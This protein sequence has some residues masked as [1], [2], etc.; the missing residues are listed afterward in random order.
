MMGEGAISPDGKFFAYNIGTGANSAIWIVRLSD[1]SARR[2]PASP[3]FRYNLAWSTDGRWLAYWRFRTRKVDEADPDAGLYVLDVRS[4][5]LRQLDSLSDPFRRP[6]EISW[7]SDGRL[8]TGY[9]E[10][11][12]GGS[13]S[14]HQSI[15]RRPNGEHA[16]APPIDLAKTIYSLAPDGR[17]A[18]IG[19]CCGGAATAV[20][21]IDARGDRCVA[22]PL[23]SPSAELHWDAAGRRLYLFVADSYPKPRIAYRVDVA[24]GGASRLYIPSIP[25]T[26]ITTTAAG[27][28]AYIAYDSAARRSSL[29]IIPAAALESWPVWSE[30]IAACPPL[31]KAVAGFVASTHRTDMDFIATRYADSSRDVALYSISRRSHYAEDFDTDIG[32][33]LRS[34]ARVGWISTRD[35]SSRALT[36]ALRRTDS[37]LWDAELDAQLDS[38]PIIQSALRRFLVADSVAPAAEIVR[39]VARDA[40]MMREAGLATSFRYRGHHPV[41]AEIPHASDAERLAIDAIAAPSVRGDVE[42]LAAIGQIPEFRSSERVWAALSPQLKRHA[43]ASPVAFVRLSP[44]AAQYVIL[45][46]VIDE[47]CAA[48]VESLLD[49][50]PAAEQN[51]LLA[52]T[53]ACTRTRSMLGIRASQALVEAI[54]SSAAG[55]SAQMIP[56]VLQRCP[57]ASS[58]ARVLDAIAR[59]DERYRA[60]SRWA[61]SRSSALIASALPMPR[62]AA[63]RPPPPPPPVPHP[64][65][66]ATG[67][68]APPPPP[69]PPGMPSRCLGSDSISAELGASLG[70]RVTQVSADSICARAVVALRRIF[71]LSGP[72][73]QAAY[74]FF[75]GDGI[76]AALPPLIYPARVMM[77][78]MKGDYLEWWREEATIPATKGIY[79]SIVTI[80]RPGLTTPARALD[81]N[82]DTGAAGFL[83]DAAALFGMPALRTTALPR[84]VREIRIW[85]LPG[86]IQP[87]TMRRFQL[88]DGRV[89]SQSAAWWTFP[90]KDSAAWRHHA[91]DWTPCR[92]GVAAGYPIRDLPGIT[93]CVSSLERQASW[94]YEW[95]S[96]ETAGIWRV[97][98]MSEVRHADVVVS[99]GGDLVIE[100][101]DGPYYRQYTMQLDP[102]NPNALPDAESRRRIVELLFRDWYAPD[103]LNVNTPTKKPPDR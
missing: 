88:R 67:R 81:L 69:P 41:P 28:L 49:A 73:D 46:C 63:P 52:I 101:R 25:S 90:A 76:V 26:Q 94:R 32:I 68:P 15:V 64:R 8:V 62:R 65:A 70:G 75:D 54:D 74:V 99:D 40:A 98:Q 11:G 5:A 77:I 97:P 9:W 10:M 47:Q 72:D 30:T 39:V 37:T 85:L 80:S 53:S 17:I 38:L 16:S 55:R 22:G 27:D 42:L 12:F 89:T 34:G 96:L 44:I 57:G 56:L 82:A 13:G 33:A 50:R 84:G 48:R 51:T 66:P 87:G 20:H 93:G 71:Q 29:I 100:L 103:P 60:Q 58:D 86:V 24:H 102:A 21:V 31:P 79:R 1:A 95:D 91:R 45:A 61:I 3:G 59:L 2:L 35:S 18:V 78:G 43:Q 36:F 4:G 14:T 92:S 83:P 19:Q 7:L 6:T 23:R